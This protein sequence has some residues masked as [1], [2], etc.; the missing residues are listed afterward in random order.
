[1]C[2]HGRSAPG[3]PFRS[4]RE[5]DHNLLNSWE[6]D[7]AGL[8]FSRE[9]ALDRLNL[10]YTWHAAGVFA[11]MAFVVGGNLVASIY[12]HGDRNSGMSD[13]RNSQEH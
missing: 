7:F 3:T 4:S 1:M 9:E 6:I 10:G 11:Y 8:G 5:D 13:V 2:A 12:R